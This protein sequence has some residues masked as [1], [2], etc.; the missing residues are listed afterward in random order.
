MDNWGGGDNLPGRLH[1]STYAY[2][3]QRIRDNMG[4][5]TQLAKRMDLTSTTPQPDLSSTGFCLASETEFVVYLPKG[6]TSVTLDMTAVSGQFAVEWLDTD[7][8][9]ITTAQHVGGGNMANFS[10]ADPDAQ[11][12]YLYKID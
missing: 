2:Y 5:A 3:F 12:L 6:V 9:I 1:G 8:G 4:W 10:N 11:V 7:T